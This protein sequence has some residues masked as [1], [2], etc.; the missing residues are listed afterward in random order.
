MCVLEGGLLKGVGKP[1]GR[2]PL[3]FQLSHGL[4]QLAFGPIAAEGGSA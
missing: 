3:G 2:R 4:A 1:S